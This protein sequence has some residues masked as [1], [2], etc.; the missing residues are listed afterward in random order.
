[1]RTPYRLKSALGPT[2]NTDLDD[3][4][5]TKHNLKRRGYYSEPSYGMTAYPDQQLFGS[6]KRY[7]KDN[8]LRVDGIMKPGGE[9]ERHLLKSDDVAMTYWRSIC[10]APHGGVNSPN[11]CWQC[12]N[13]GYR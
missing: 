9:T 7:Q 1:M 5:A 4:W 10:G 12:W 3:V 8:S 6:I 13:K 11:I 2:Y